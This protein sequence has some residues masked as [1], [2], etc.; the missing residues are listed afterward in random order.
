VATTPGPTPTVEPPAPVPPAAPGTPLATLVIRDFSVF[1]WY[2]QTRQR[3]HYWPKLT[4]AETGNVSAAS[5]TSITFELLDVGPDG[6]VPPATGSFAVPAGGE[7]RLD[8][9]LYGPWL[10]IDGTARA[11]RVSVQIGFVDSD[12]RTGLISAVA[13]VSR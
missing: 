6:R 4:V 3:F 1:G 7:L 9:D 10:E 11:E 13:T 2:D 8:E 12:R 5:I